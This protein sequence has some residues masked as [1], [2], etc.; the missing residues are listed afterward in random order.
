VSP[1]LTARPSISVRLRLVGATAGMALIAAA[2]PFFGGDGRSSAVV[3]TVLAV[4][5]VCAALVSH[6][7]HASA[8]AT[9][10]GRLAWMSVGTT[11]ALIG[12]VLT[13]L[14]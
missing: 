5:I 10:D 11:L 7:L 8:R 14:S 2:V 1:L 13:L 12:L 4:A 3:P 9:G 6:L